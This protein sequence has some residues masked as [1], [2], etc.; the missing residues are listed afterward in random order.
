MNVSAIMTIRNGEDFVEQAISSILEQ[1]CQALELIVVDDGSK[2]NTVFLIENLM[3]LSKIPI[4]LLKTDGVGRAK[5]L[6]MA[7]DI[8][9]GEWVAN[10]DVDD[11]WHPNK[12]YFQAQAVENYPSFD[13]FIT[14]SEM[15]YGSDHKDGWDELERAGVR[16]LEKSDFYI[17]NPVNHS[18]V[19]I[20]RSVLEKV[21]LYNERLVRQIDADLWIRLLKGGYG[22]CYVD[23]PLTVKRLHGGQSFEGRRS[24]AYAWGAMMVGYRQLLMLNAPVYYYPIPFFKFIYRAVPRGMSNVVRKT[25]RPGL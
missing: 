1:S 6:N 5:A 12:I 25:L 18:S 14:G 4:R 11:S 2:D 22:F 21:G 7:I 19:M 16:I 24:L 3:A 13:V 20:R 15:V 9:S 8:A 10:L 17:R 23:S